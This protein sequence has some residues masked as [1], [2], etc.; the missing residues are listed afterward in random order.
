MLVL[1][2]TIAGNAQNLLSNPGFEQ[3]WSG[4]SGTG[5]VGTEPWSPRSGTNGMAFKGWEAS[6]ATLSQSVGVSTNGTFT[7]SIWCRREFRYDVLTNNLVIEWLDSANNP[8]QPPTTRSWANVPPD[9]FWHQIYVSGSCS[10][11]E[12]ANI[13]VKVEGAWNVM[14]GP[15]VS[16]MVDDA[17]LYSGTR[18]GVNWFANG[19][20]EEGAYDTGMAGSQ[21]EVNT[22][23]AGERTSWSPR[24]GSYGC[25]LYGF[26]EIVNDDHAFLLSQSVYP[27]STGEYTF[28]SWT[29]IETNMWLTNA[30]M[31]L[32]WFDETLTNEVQTMNVTDVDVDINNTWQQFFVSGVLTNPNVY[33]IKAMWFLQWEQSTAPGQQAG[34]IDDCL[35]LYQ[36]DNGTQPALDMDWAYFSGRSREPTVEQVPGTNVGTF[37]QVDY[38]T[39]TTTFYV[40]ADDPSQCVYTPP[41]QNSWEMK[42]SFERPDYPGT[43]ITEWS[44]MEKVGTMEL[45][46]GS[47]HGLPSAGTKTV[48]LWRHEMKQPCNSNGVPYTEQVRVYYTPFT[49]ATNGVIQT[50]YNYLLE[51]GAIGTNNLGQTYG[52]ETSER[53]YFYDNTR[54]EPFTAFTNGTFENPVETTTTLA[55]TGWRGTG[56]AARQEWAARTGFRGAYFPSWFS[57]GQEEYQLLQD[58]DASAG[59]YTFSAWFLNEPMANPTSLILRMDWYNDSLDLLQR[60]ENDITDMPNDGTW[61]PAYVTGACSSSDVSF[62]RLSVYGLYNPILGPGNSATLMDNFDFYSGAYQPYTTFTNGSFEQ[63]IFASSWRGSGWATIPERD[64]DEDASCRKDWAWRSGSYGMALLSFTNAAQPAITNFTVKVVQSVTPG[65]GTYTF[66]AWM[67]QETNAILSN[68]IMTL[69]WLDRD[70]QPVQP[71][72]S[73]VVAGPLGAW[74][75]RYDLTGTCTD[76]NLFEIRAGVYYEW[77][78]TADDWKGAQACKLDDAHIVRG[79]KPYVADGLDW[80]YFNAGPV[81]PDDEQV[82][83][84]SVTFREIDYATTT[85]TFRALADVY[86]DLVAQENSMGIYISYQPTN[87]AEW[88][89]VYTNMTQ[90]GTV[91]I[92]AA[93]QFHGLPTVGTKTL[94][95]WEYE[96]TQPLDMGGDPRTNI[97][98]IYHVPYLQRVYSEVETNRMFLGLDSQEATYTN[99]YLT[100]PQE[101]FASSFGNDFYYTNR[102]TINTNFHEGIP[103]SW[104]EQY[105]P[106]DPLTNHANYDNDGDGADNMSEYIADTVPTNDASVFVAMVTNEITAA[107]TFTLQAGPPTSPDRE[108]DVWWSTNLDAAI[109]TWTP[110]GMDMPGVDAVTPV[111]LTVTNSM[112]EGAY[113]TG[114]R[115]P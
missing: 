1:V 48:G 108:Y 28:A 81:S 24:S 45:S 94:A 32:M 58:V 60:D 88:V 103:N 93:S 83:D 18:T 27:L 47:F 5:N 37:L 33:E 44:Q 89:T 54:F 59:T 73:N 13:R 98:D 79:D 34:R 43:W 102:Y 99:N 82:P 12:L 16:Y 111:N 114:V 110:M 80:L 85:T 3:G 71:A 104:W 46:A 30:E 39:T 109:Q 67:L 75:T 10:S 14:G 64:G 70:Y 26:N 36:S 107:G 100:N 66:S 77:S 105:W 87:N 78:S 115:L 2:G 7:F 76:T 50:D 96:F 72:T 90:V 38:Q 19:S 106:V 57:A 53:D 4:W 62:V 113:R 15:A 40:I 61:H 29:S 20:F 55:N 9:N 84:T 65:T 92:S 69:E 74:W 42:T 49:K 63:G 22:N 56:G 11:S 21:W 23:S 17:A 86:T 95:L 101:L 52:R 41:D 31:R 91:D 35:M 112:G 97:I 6:P 51:N 25:A 8:L 68:M